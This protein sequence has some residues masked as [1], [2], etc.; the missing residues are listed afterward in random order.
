VI[1]SE[2]MVVPNDTAVQRREREGACRATDATVRCDG[3]LGAL[4]GIDQFDDRRISSNHVRRV[5]TGSESIV[6]TAD[7][8]L[9]WMPGATPGGS[10]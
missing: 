1:V 7:S 5:T 9:A 3:G 6:N 2:H 4:L 10:A 8:R